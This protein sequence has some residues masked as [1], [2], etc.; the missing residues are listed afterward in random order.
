MSDTYG[1]GCPIAVALDV[2]GDRWMLLLLRDLGH[3]PM[4]FSDLQVINPKISP[5]L[6]SKRL[7]QLQEAGL[8]TK[9]DLPPPGAATVYELGPQAREAVLPVLNA[10]GRF[11]AYLFQAAPAGPIDALLEQMRRN[12]HWVLAKGIDFEATFRF[13]LHPHEFGITVGPTVFEPTRQPPAQPT[14]TVESDAVTLTR[15][16]NAGITLGEAE[17]QGW[18]QI[19]GDRAAATTLLD[20]LSLGRLLP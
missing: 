20:R 6:L 1:Q 14:A 10:L 5:N 17:G 13:K 9:R 3:A 2:I 4:R 12:G 16:F 15:L 8:V 18:L 11:G 19:T 7:R